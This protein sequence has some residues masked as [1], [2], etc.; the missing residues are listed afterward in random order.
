MEVFSVVLF[1]LVIFCSMFISFA[2]IFQI[3]T[4]EFNGPK[5]MWILI[6]MIGFIGPILWLT[7]GRK[8][9]IKK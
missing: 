4:N 1:M 8:L 5:G 9:I 3:L 7:K 2:A 6:S